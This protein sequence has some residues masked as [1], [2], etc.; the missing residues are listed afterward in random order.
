ML[1]CEKVDQWQ[2]PNTISDTRLLFCLIVEQGRLDFLL[3]L[4]NTREY[5]VNLYLNISGFIYKAAIVNHPII[6]KLGVI[7]KNFPQLGLGQVPRVVRNF[8]SFPPFLSVYD[9]NILS[10]QPSQEYLPNS[11][12]SPSRLVKTYCWPKFWPDRK[13]WYLFHHGAFLTAH[14]MILEETDLNAKGFVDAWS[15]LDWQIG[16]TL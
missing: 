12:P 1:H 3:I 5:C 10:R 16:G 4:F 13:R 15:V 6:S 14:A 11:R 9:K 2:L 7:V 8:P